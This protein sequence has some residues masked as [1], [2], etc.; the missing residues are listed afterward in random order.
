[1]DHISVPECISR[2]QTGRSPV[3]ADAALEW[4]RTGQRLAGKTA[5]RS[6]SRRRLPAL[7]CHRFVLLCRAGQ[8]QF[9][10]LFSE[11]KWRHTGHCTSSRGADAEQAL[12]HL[13]NAL[14]LFSL[15]LLGQ[16]FCSHWDIIVSRHLFWKSTNPVGIEGIAGYIE[17]HKSGER[18]YTQQV[19][20]SRE[21][22]EI[23]FIFVDAICK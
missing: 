8:S 1:M 6:L 2:G 13:K 19:C 12:R 18:I 23:K 22:T 17:R 21:L 15:A 10:C 4:L 7:R 20:I 5:A 9:S 14:S 16:F 11:K 3:R